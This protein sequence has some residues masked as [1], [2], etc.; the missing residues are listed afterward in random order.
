MLPSSSLACCCCVGTHA[1]TTS[2]TLNLS[3]SKLYET[4]TRPQQTGSVGNIDGPN[5]ESSTVPT[6]ILKHCAALI[7]TTI[8]DDLYILSLSTVPLQ[9]FFFEFEIRDSGSESALF[10]LFLCEI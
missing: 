8:H 1:C 5:P 4:Q 9:G 2:P 6:R 10:A 7:P 3:L